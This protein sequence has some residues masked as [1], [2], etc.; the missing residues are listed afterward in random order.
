MYADKCS[1]PR[2]KVSVLQLRTQSVPKSVLNVF[3]IAIS[4]KIGTLSKKREKCSLKM[5]VKVRG[6]DK[7]REEVTKKKRENVP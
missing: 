2:I 7:E 1:L 4:E 3:T 6:Y 5:R